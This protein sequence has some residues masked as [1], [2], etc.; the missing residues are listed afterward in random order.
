MSVNANTQIY[1]KVIDRAAMIRLYERRVN[2][3]VE[4]V[5]DGHAVKIDKL[6]REAELSQKGFERL[7]ETVDQQLSSTYKETFSL[8]KRSLFDLVSD[9]VSYAYQNL[10]TAVGK[11]WKT[12]RPPKRVAEEIVLETPLYGDTRLEAGWAGIATGERK[13]LEAVIRKGIAEGK[14]VDQIALEV[15][16][17]NVHNISRNQAKGLVVTAITATATQADHAV[18]KANEKALQG[19]QY[20]AVLDARTTPI[21]AHRD[22]EIYLIG[23]KTHLP[24]AHFHCRS[25]TVPV[26]KSWQQ[27]AELEGVAQV[28]KE[29]IAN[30]SKKQIAFY[31]G[32]TPLRE[33]YADWLT[34]QPKDVQFRH[35]GD[36][37]KVEMFNNGQLELSQFFN[38]EGNSIGIKELRRMTDSGYTLSLRVLWRSLLVIS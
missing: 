3:K 10:E 21:C 36:Y 32:Q 33:T 2:G 31:D 13:R 16:R 5:L 23:D 24:P 26:F 1:D 7:R 4:L 20:V 14:T 30:L 17:G 11:I 15:R 37:K 6:I 22:G 29:N 19:W 28:R 35:L 34:R 8:T 12:E 9:Q 38:P 25:T 27:M 18:Y